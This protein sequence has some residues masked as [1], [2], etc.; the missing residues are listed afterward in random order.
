MDYVD[1]L[2]CH[3]LEDL[4]GGVQIASAVGQGARVIVFDEPTSSLTRHE[5]AR[6]YDLIRRLQARGVTAAPG[7]FVIRTPVSKRLQSVAELTSRLSW[8]A[9][10]SK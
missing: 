8:L 5:T 10:P 2:A 4:V 9:M 7:R 1:V 6:L 3:H